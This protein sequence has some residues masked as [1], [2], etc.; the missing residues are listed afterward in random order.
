M[1]LFQQFPGVS[2]NQHVFRNTPFS[3]AAGHAAI[4]Q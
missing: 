1:L 4:N 3:R 2:D